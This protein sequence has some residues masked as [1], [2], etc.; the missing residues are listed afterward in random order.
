MPKSSR[1]RYSLLAKYCC[2]ND[3]ICCRYLNISGLVSDNERSWLMVSLA[4]QNKRFAIIFFPSNK[5]SIPVTCIWDRFSGNE[6]RRKETKKVKRQNLPKTFGTKCS[7]FFRNKSL[8]CF[9]NTE[10]VAR[11]WCEIYGWH[12]IVGNV[13]NQ[14]A[15][16]LSLELSDALE[17]EWTTAT[18]RRPVTH[19]L[20]T[21]SSSVQRRT[22]KLEFSFEC[23]VKI[24]CV[25][26]YELPSEGN[27]WR[28]EGPWPNFHRF[29]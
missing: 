13:G 28:L 22:T 23:R 24:D 4:T 6:I 5:S 12:N 10:N 8:F 2:F 7:K 15:N 14:A 9:A 3:A 18:N 25:D 19:I 29:R 11:T 27:F 21:I 17:Q 20:C 16:E 1:C 26:T